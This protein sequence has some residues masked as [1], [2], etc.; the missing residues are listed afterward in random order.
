MNAQSRCASWVALRE[1]LGL[2]DPVRDEGHY[3]QLLEVAEALMDEL[4]RD[5]TSPYGG[6]A[7]LIADRIREYEVRVHPWPDD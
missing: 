2:R 4:A 6:L 1:N 5:D 7:N 3:K